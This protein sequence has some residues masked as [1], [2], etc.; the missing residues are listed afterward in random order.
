MTNQAHFYWSTQKCWAGLFINTWTTRG[1]R[2]C[3]FRG[4]LCLERKRS[5]CIWKKRAPGSVLG[6]EN[7]WRHHITGCRS[8]ALLALTLMESSCCLKASWASLLGENIRLCRELLGGS[9]VGTAN[10]LPSPSPGDPSRDRGRFRPPGE[11]REQNIVSKCA[12]CLR[13]LS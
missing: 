11:V 2:N 13:Q 9:V 1:F 6:V 12:S 5:D 7:E 10:T 4:F 8:D 3:L